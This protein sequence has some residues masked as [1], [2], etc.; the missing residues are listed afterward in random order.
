MQDRPDQTPPPTPPQ[1]RLPRWD[2]SAL[3]PGKNSPEF[4]NALAAIDRDVKKF[5]QDWRGQVAKADG[6]ALGAAVARFE[7]ITETIARVETY[8]SLLRAADNGEDAFAAK[9]NDRLRSSA[10]EMLFFT[11]EINRIPEPALLQ[12]IAAPDLARYAPWIAGLRASRPHQLDDEAEKYR[13]LKE[14]VAEDAWRRLFDLTMQGLR[15]DVGGEKLTEAETLNIIDND[16]DPARRRQAWE[17]FAKG[18]GENAGGFALI[19][20]TLA[21]LK[22]AEDTQRGFEKPEDSRHLENRIDRDT[23]GALAAAVKSS[24][25]KTSHRYYG[26]KA[27]K[28]GNARLHPADRNAPLADAPQK[29]IPWAEAKEIVLEAFAKLSPEMEKIGRRFFDEGWIDAEPRAGKDSGG[30]SHPAVPSAHPYILL[31]Y[32]GTTADVMTLAH[33]LGHGIHQVMAA[34][35]G[36]LMADTPL[37]VAETASV[38]GEM[39]VFRALLDREEDPALRRAMIAEK[40]EGMLNT[41]VRQTAFFTFEQKLHAEYREKGELSPERLG[42]LWRETSRE[43]LGPAVNM[44]VEGAQHFWA[45]VPHFIHTPFYVYAYAFGDCLV[46]TLYDAYEHATDKNDFAQKYADMLAAGGSKSHETL[47][48]P[49]GFD[50]NDPAF[51]RKGLGVIEKYIDELVKLD[52]KIERAAKAEK[53]IR[54][55]GRELTAEKPDEAND[56]LA[57][58]DFKKAARKKPPRAGLDGAPQPKAPKPPKNGGGAGGAG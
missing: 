25:A 46:N 49:F 43:S 32:F 27:K 40:I 20:N 35:Q 41:V 39:L 4:Q 37:T 28:N 54:D 2:L 50:V 36:Q 19:T 5:A 8:V 31:N 48:E 30:F 3:F 55:A 52:Q 29:Y 33:E 51:W 21:A 16:R 47:L 1:D 9:V 26:W 11:L 14:G 34:K 24:Y 44:D 17:A 18:L 45:Y 13:H 58:S 6:A 23:V 12:K 53:D 56:N 57:R 7:Q 10:Q 42:E 22:A 38:F 15:F